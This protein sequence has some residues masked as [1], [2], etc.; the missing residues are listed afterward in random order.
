MAA[1]P[2]EPARAFAEAA[3]LLKDWAHRVARTAGADTR[4][5]FVRR[6][7]RKRNQRAGLALD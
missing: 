6:Y 4:P 7:W 3:Q 5:G 1:D 2:P